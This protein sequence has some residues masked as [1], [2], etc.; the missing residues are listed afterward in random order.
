MHDFHIYRDGSLPF[1]AQQFRTPEVRVLR[2]EYW[3]LDLWHHANLAAPYWRL[4]WNP[5]HGAWVELDGRRW[6]LGPERLVLIPPRTPF[7]T[8]LEDTRPIPPEPGVMRGMPY[9]APAGGRSTGH[10]A[11]GS[12]RHFFIHFT[13]GFPCDNGAPRIFSF[14]VDSRLRTLLGTLTTSLRAGQSHFDHQQTFGLLEVIHHAMEKVPESY[15]PH[16][17]DDSRVLRVMQHID[18]NY[19]LPL[20]NG[21]FSRIA[22]MNPNAFVRLFKAKTQFTP[23]EYLRTRRIGEASILLIQTDHS[24]EEIAAQC[25]FFDRN[26]FSRIFQRHSGMGPATYRRSRRR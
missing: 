18:A 23:L 13:A 12:V 26:H 9:Q 21:D 17:P 14:P 24:I 5:D 11:P 8:G 22:R 25:G 10:R 16:P 2:V 15:W 19:A 4:Y 3:V 1:P 7:R 6:P 20:R